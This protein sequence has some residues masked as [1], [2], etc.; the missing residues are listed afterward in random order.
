MN[1]EYRCIIYITIIK[2]LKCVEFS[3]LSFL[4]IKLLFKDSVILQ[5]IYNVFSQQLLCL[6]KLAVQTEETDIA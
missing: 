3:V 2:Y 6:K 4:V 1:K 5:G